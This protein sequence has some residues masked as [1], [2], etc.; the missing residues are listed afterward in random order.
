MGKGSSMPWAARA[1]TISAF[2]PRSRK[3]VTD[4][5][6]L[7][8]CGGRSSAASQRK[9]GEVRPRAPVS[10]LGQSPRDQNTWKREPFWTWGYL[11][12]VPDVKKYVSRIDR[13]QQQH[14]P[15]GFVYGVIKKFGDDQGGNLAA[16]ITYYGFISLFPLLLVLVTLFG[17]FF[18]SHQDAIVNSALADFPIIGDQIKDQLKAPKGSGL[19][20]AIGVLGAL[21]GGLGIANASQDAMNRVWAVPFRTRPGFFPRVLRSLAI[22]GVLGIGIIGITVVST[23]ATNIGVGPWLRVFTVTASLILNTALFALAF[24]VLTRGLSWNDV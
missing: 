21:W 2:R 7:H 14:R 12:N 8:R 6:L 16:L 5:L 17:F 10:R 11:P 1:S 18:R 9:T 13:F 22:V 4:I 20:L 19:G 15:F 24:R 23:I 3:V